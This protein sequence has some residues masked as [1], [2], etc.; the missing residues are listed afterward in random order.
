MT[1]YATCPLFARCSADEIRQLL[2]WLQYKEQVYERGEVILH[3]GETTG[4][5][6]LVLEGQVSME[7]D[8]FLGNR[9]LLGTARAGEVFGEAYACL[10]K[11]KLIVNAVADMHTKVCMMLFPREIQHGSS[12]TELQSKF[13]LNLLFLTANKNLSLSKRSMHTGARTIRGRLMSY[14]TELA[15]RSGSNHFVLSFSR[16]QLADYLNVERSALSAELSKM[17]KDGLIRYRKND[18]ELC[19]HD[20]S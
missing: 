4:E 17:A 11:Q 13:L 15:M 2:Q 6:G 5:M 14:F 18:V 9:T 10:S 8:D 12:L 1:F 7:F 20:E 16:Q 3:A 19:A